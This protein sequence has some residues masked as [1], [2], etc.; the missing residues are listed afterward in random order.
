[1]NPISKGG[2]TITSRPDQV[3][4]LTMPDGSRVFVKAFKFG[5]DIR[6]NI[7]APN[8]ISIKRIPDPRVQ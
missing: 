8:E 3:I 7:V 1:M 4:Q 2:L 5:N 6:V